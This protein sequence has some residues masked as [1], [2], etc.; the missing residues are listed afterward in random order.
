MAIKCMFLNFT[1]KSTSYRKLQAYHCNRTDA[2]R[3]KVIKKIDE[4]AGK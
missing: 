1:K 3:P 4:K 2:A